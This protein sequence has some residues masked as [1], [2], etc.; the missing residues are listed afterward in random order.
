[1]FIASATS[2]HSYRRACLGIAGGMGV[3]ALDVTM[4]AAVILVAPT[5]VWPMLVAAPASPARIGL[6]LQYLPLSHAE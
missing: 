2:R 6:T 3:I 1:M 5:M 4:L